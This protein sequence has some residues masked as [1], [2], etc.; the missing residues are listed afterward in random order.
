MP[1]KKAQAKREVVTY[2]ETNDFVIPADEDGRTSLKELR[3]LVEATKHLPEDT[4]VE[5]DGD[6]NRDTN[7]YENYIVVRA[8]INWKDVIKEW[9][10][11]PED[12]NF[13]GTEGQIL[14]NLGVTASDFKSEP[15]MSRL[16][17]PSW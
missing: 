12:V 3:E 15:D 13:D 9:G 4:V 5:S 17:S 8:D 1:V 7:M 16:H 10:V 6:Y 11:D 14:I 2:V